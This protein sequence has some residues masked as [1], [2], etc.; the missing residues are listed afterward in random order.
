MGITIFQ[1]IILGLVEGFTEF[2]PVS[3]T[4]HLLLSRALL[5]ISASQY[6]DAFIVAIQSG[7]I[8]AALWYFWSFFKKDKSIF[9][10]V[11]VAFIPTALVG[12]L[13]NKQIHSLF[14]EKSVIGF[15]LLLGGIIFL[16]LPDKTLSERPL[17]WKE[18]ILLGIFQI[19]AFIP[20]MSRSGSLLIG[21]I[22]LGLPKRQITEFSF[23]LALP[24]IFGA[25]AV[26]LW[27]NRTVISGTTVVPLIVGGIVACAVAILTMHFFLRFIEKPNSLKVFGW[28]RILIGIFTLFFFL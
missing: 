13:L 21:G 27:S 25:T 18:V 28:Y 2:I 22:L 24:T 7:A 11:A 23:L 4:A 17:S 9:L 19:F 14:N 12:I 1:S 20:G 5:G 15:A 6:T 26:D 8:L 16:F 3:S 10:K